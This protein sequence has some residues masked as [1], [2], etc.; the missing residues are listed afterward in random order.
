MCACVCAYVRACVCDQTNDCYGWTLVFLSY[1]SCFFLTMKLSMYF[2]GVE[3]VR[4]NSKW[5][6][7]KPV[8]KSTHT[9]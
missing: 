1:L 2:T 8:V 9:V 4:G 3:V 5:H 7:V 6:C